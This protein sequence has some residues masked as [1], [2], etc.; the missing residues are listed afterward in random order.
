MIVRLA[1]CIVTIWLVTAVGIR[2]GIVSG[3]ITVATFIISGIVGG[4]A[5]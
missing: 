4:I 5:W 1:C 3:D 2:T